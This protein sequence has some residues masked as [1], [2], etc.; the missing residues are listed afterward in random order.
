MKSTDRVSL[1]RNNNSLATVESSKNRLAFKDILKTGSVI[2]HEGFQQV[3]TIDRSDE[4]SESLVGYNHRN[5]FVSISPDFQ[6]NEVLEVGINL[7]GMTELPFFNSA[8]FLSKDKL[9]LALADTSSTQRFFRAN[10]H[11]NPAPSLEK[12]RPAFAERI[13]LSS[14]KGFLFYSTSSNL[15]RLEEFD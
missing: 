11:L 8:L 7:T 12:M 4:A 1:L 10:T 9:L 2:L 5:Q 14:W 6:K 13:R 3:G 15:Y